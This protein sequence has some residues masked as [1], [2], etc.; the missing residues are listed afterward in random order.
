MCS[1]HCSVTYKSSDYFHTCHM[2]PKVFK[3][4]SEQESCFVSRCA[5][6]ALL[7]T[8]ANC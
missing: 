1:K 2:M 8:C 7:E 6:K 4:G 5:W 3:A